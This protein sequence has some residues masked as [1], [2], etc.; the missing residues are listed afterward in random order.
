MLPKRPQGRDSAESTTV[1]C[2]L[3]LGPGIVLLQR[4]GQRQQQDGRGELQE[5]GPS[6]G[7]RR[8]LLGRPGVVLGDDAGWL[9]REGSRVD[10]ADAV[11]GH[12]LLGGGAVADVLEVRGGVLACARTKKTKTKT[13][14]AAVSRGHIISKQRYQLITTV[15]ESE[16]TLLTDGRQQDLVAAGVLL[17][18][19]RDVVHLSRAEAARPGGG[20]QTRSESIVGR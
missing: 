4:E 5:R 1:S 12:E 15:L 10:L 3:C 7:A 16:T 14:A 13:A 8:G 18:E 17:H 2:L 19:R 9:G 11:L 20:R 6:A